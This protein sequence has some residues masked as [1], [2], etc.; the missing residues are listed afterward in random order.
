VFLL[1][2]E[3]CHAAMTIEPN[4]LPGPFIGLERRGMSWDGFSQ[5]SRCGGRGKGVAVGQR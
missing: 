5:R 4:R 2:L 3:I 1:K